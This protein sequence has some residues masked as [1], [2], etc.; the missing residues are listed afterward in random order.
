MDKKNKLVDKKDM[1]TFIELFRKNAG[2]I[3]MTCKEFGIT[4]RAYYN[5]LEKDEYFKEKIDE[6]LESLIDFAESA[7]MKQIK[8]GN[9]TAILFFLKTKGKHRGYVE[10]QEVNHKGIKNIEIDFIDI[11]DNNKKI[12]E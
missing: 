4:R 7:L 3:S 9:T 2:N 8:E 6:V 12:N 10:T 5:K 11:N 1:D